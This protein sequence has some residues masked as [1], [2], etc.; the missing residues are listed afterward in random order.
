MQVYSSWECRHSQKTQKKGGGESALAISVASECGKVCGQVESASGS[1]Y[2]RKSKP[3][4]AK[5]ENR[6]EE[7]G[8][9]QDHC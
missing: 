6:F 1:S 4:L 7:L 9:L 3:W 8:G 5:L 2:L